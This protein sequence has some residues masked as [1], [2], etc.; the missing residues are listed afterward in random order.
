MCVPALEIWRE[1]L[2]QHYTFAILTN[3]PGLSLSKDT[4]I[5]FM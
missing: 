1:L 5:F 3:A 2:I 4:E